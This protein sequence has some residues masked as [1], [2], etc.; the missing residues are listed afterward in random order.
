MRGETTTIID[1]KTRN[2]TSPPSSAD[3]TF[4][5]ICNRTRGKDEKKREKEKRN[6]ITNKKREKDL[7]SEYRQ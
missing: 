5:D 3:D 2:L 7:T 1:K 4:L 6:E